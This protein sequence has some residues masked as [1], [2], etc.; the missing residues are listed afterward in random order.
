MFGSAMIDMPPEPGIWTLYF[1]KHL[2]KPGLYSLRF[3]DA[4]GTVYSGPHYL[5]F[6]SPESAAGYLCAWTELEES[7]DLRRQLAEGKTLETKGH[8]DVWLP[9]V[10]ALYH[11]AGPVMSFNASAFWANGGHQSARIPQDP[12][13]KM[14]EDCDLLLQAH[15]LN[16]PGTLIS[17]DEHTPEWTI[18]WSSYSW[19]KSVSNIYHPVVKVRYETGA[20][21]S[22]TL[23]RGPYRRKSDKA[24]LMP[25]KKGEYR[26]EWDETP[27][28]SARG[29]R[30]QKPTKSFTKLPANY[31]E[32][33]EEERKKWT[34]EAALAIRESLR[35]RKREGGDTSQV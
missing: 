20:E 5:R 14:P 34:A 4:T 22:F 35:V 27:D 11:S 24:I 7:D 13:Q 33:S 25:T 32:L 9:V 15:E 2:K 6:E 8:S 31:S 21:E 17:P 12:E 18:V 3:R 28:F 1:E 26:I 30:E 19:K 16:D 29:E 23:L 10:Y